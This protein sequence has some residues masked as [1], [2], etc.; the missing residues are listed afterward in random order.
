MSADNHSLNS[1]TSSVTYSSLPVSWTKQFWI[2]LFSNILSIICC[3]FVLFHL[4]SDRILRRAV[5]NHVI[6]VILFLTLICELTDIPWLLFYYRWGIVWHSTP[7]FC[8][9]WKYI[10][11]VV[12]VATSKL[13]AWTSI[14]RHILIFHDKWVA[15]KKKRFF[16]HYIPLVSIVAYCLIYYAFTICIFQCGEP[17]YYKMLYWGYSSCVYRNPAVLFFEFITGGILCSLIIALFSIAL[18]IRIVLQKRRVHQPIRWRRHRKMTIQLLFITSLFYFIYLPPVILAVAHLL[19]VP[20]YVGAEYSTFDVQF[21]TYYITFLLPFACAAS[22][23]QLQIRIKNSIPWRCRRQTRIV[24]P[25][26]LPM[27]VRTNNRSP[28]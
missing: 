17:F 26:Q 22:L 1:S 2:I 15:T 7:T 28:A 14:E 10:D 19:G 27:R 23:P 25:E 11:I 8:L 12:Y 9:I 20:S 13:V 18:V 21:L 6:I 3:L 16:I 5:H 4:L 24:A